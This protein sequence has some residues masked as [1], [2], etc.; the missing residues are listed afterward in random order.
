M[1][2]KPGEQSTPQVAHVSSQK[3]AASGPKGSNSTKKR[4]SNPSNQL[5]SDNSK[6]KKQMLMLQ[7]LQNF[8]DFGT[9]ETN[10]DVTKAATMKKPI[11]TGARK[12]SKGTQPPVGLS[13]DMEHVI[14]TRNNEAT[15]SFLNSQRMPN[16]EHRLNELNVKPN[17]LRAQASSK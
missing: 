4:E 16:L 6:S 10:Q 2:K 9:F 7:L 11:N 12:G 14:A 15:K 5:L 8:Q 3:K 13:I 17:K 1:S